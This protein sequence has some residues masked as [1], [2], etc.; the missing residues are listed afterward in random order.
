MLDVDIRF[1][2]DGRESA[3][4]Y[5]NQLELHKDSLTGTA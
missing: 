2:K 5:S 1:G 3:E 4:S